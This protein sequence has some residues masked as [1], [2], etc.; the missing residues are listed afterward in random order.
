MGAALTEEQI[1]EA[2]RDLPGWNLEGREIVLER[3]FETYADGVLFANGAAALAEAMDHHPELTIG[4]R[5]VRVAVSTHSAGG[6]TN[7]DLEF[8]RRLGS[9]GR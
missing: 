9:L 5:R 4:Y 6:A 2:L 1:R 3:A 8:A 7:L